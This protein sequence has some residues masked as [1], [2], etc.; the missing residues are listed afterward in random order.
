[1]FATTLAAGIDPESHA[2]ITVISLDRTPAAIFAGTPDARLYWMT[3]QG[4]FGTNFDTPDWVAA[5]NTQR[6]AEAAR[7]A[8]WFAMGFAAP[9]PALRTLNFS[10]ERPDEFMS[11]FR[12]SPFAQEAQF[13]FACELI[14]H[15]KMGQSGTLDVVCLMTGSMELLGYETG[16]WSPLMQQMALQTDKHLEKLFNQLAKVPGEGNYNLALVGGHGIPP[17]PPPEL[18]SRM[19]VSGEHVALAVQRVLATSATGRVEKYIYPFLYL[20]T[21]A[22]RDPEPFRLAAG[23]AALQHPSVSGFF[24]AG[25]NCSVHNEWEARFRNSFHPTRSGDVMLSYLP[26]YVENFEAD[27][28]VSYGS[29]YNYDAVVPLA[30][31]GPQFRAGEHEQPVESVDLAPTL[32]RVIGVP[33]PSS[34]TGR[35]LAEALAE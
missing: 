29:I 22:V 6:K 13:D 9:A 5:Y 2:R 25:G 33:P 12:S 24:T 11:L 21:D 34:S 17:E 20:N 14:D 16:A 8:K 23:R 10:P 18:R 7:N 3:E 19:A 28:G 4:G 30:F 35:A 32:A 26:E 31:Y 1:M 27:R 15:E